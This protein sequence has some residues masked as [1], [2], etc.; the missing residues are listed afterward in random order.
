MER[1]DRECV[2]EATE[3]QCNRK[4][5][6]QKSGAGTQVDDIVNIGIGI[7]EMVSRYARKCG[8]LDMVTLT[9]E[10]GGIGGFPVSG[11]AFGAMIGAA[12]VYD[13]ANQFDLYDNGGLIS[14]LWVRWKWID[15]ET[16]MHIE[17]PELLP[18]LVDLR[19]LRQKHQRL[20]S[21]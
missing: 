20:Y 1:K 19:I 16:S 5:Y 21:V 15:M 9:V 12:S 3:K 4:Y 13:M 17:V 18:E 11:E 8:M 6:R 7:P 10:S 14:V 2:Y